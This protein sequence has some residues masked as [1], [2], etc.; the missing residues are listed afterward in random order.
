MQI[1]GKL[2]DEHTQEIAAAEGM[3][4]LMKSIEQRKR[5]VSRISSQ[6]SDAAKSGSEESPSVRD[7]A[8]LNPEAR[9]Q[10]ALRRTMNNFETKI[11]DAFSPSYDAH[12][13]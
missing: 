10:R 3:D 2:I 7:D 13:Y 4:P 12:L 5:I 6:D 8:E 1:L 11:N 9:L